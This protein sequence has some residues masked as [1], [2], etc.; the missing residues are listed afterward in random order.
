MNKLKLFCIIGVPAL[1]ASCAG[2]VRTESDDARTFELSQFQ[3]V[4]LSTGRII[5]D[6]PDL[7][8]I[9]KNIKIVNDSIIAI[10][11][12]SGNSQVKL[13]NLNSGEWQ[14]A[15]MRGEGP[16]E[17]LSVTSLST[18]S[19][20]TLWISGLMDKK[21]MTTGWNNDGNEAV[22]ELKYHSP[23]DLL[24]GV[25]D[26]HGGLIGLP[27]VSRNLRAIRLNH[28]GETTDSLGT[29][30]SVA[31]PDSIAP[32]N[33]MFQ[34]DIAYS[35]G[36]GKLVVANKSWNQIGIYS[37]ADSGKIILKYPLDKDIEIKKSGRGNGYTYNPQPMWFMFSDVSADD[38]GFAVGYI[39]VEVKTKEDFNRGIRRLL[40]F[41]WDGNPRR[42]FSFGED[43]TTFDVDFNNRIIYT[44]ENR[45][46]PT[47]VRYEF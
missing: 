14:N 2:K 16:L 41:D 7:L 21:V 33:F 44:I 24:R 1:L 32:D 39:G 3:N 22:T 35:S 43:V 45:P 30:P 6:D 4:D 29:F 40:E 37:V 42:S 38:N 34:A 10:C 9:T 11:Q 46:D 36:N 28:L 8:G 26:N 12:T 5:T 25:T 31:L 47:L 19:G 23:E 27:A 20:K 17:M 18:D 13:Y 15:V